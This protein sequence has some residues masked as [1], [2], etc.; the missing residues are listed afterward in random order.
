M[1]KC[2]NYIQH[3]LAVPQGNITYIALVV[4]LIYVVGGIQSMYTHT[5]NINTE[6]R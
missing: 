6:F 2:S 3:E 5:M 1:H 4:P